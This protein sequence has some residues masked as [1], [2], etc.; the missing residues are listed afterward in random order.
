[1]PHRAFRSATPD[2][3]FFDR[4]GA[5][6]PALAAARRLARIQRIE[7]NP[8]LTCRECHPGSDPPNLAE[9][10]GDAA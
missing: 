7:T 1:M 10:M 3:V 8:A 9:E 4:A 2:E 6:A 5:L